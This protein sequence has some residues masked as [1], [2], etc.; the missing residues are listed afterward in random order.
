[1]TGYYSRKS[2]CMGKAG[3]LIQ[4][5]GHAFELGDQ[6]QMFAADAL[7]HSAVGDQLPDCLRSRSPRLPSQCLESEIEFG[8]EPYRDA[9][10]LFLR[11]A[12]GG[13]T[14]FISCLF[15]RFDS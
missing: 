7:L 6:L 10:I 11:L 1:M 13:A 3:K 15:H 8:V 9:V 4:V 12:F 14:A 5:T 2:F